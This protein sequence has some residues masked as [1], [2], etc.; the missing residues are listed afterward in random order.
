M[1]TVSTTPTGSRTKSGSK[2]REFRAE[3]LS[4]IASKYVLGYEYKSMKPLYL[5]LLAT[6]GA[7]RP[8]IASI[9]TGSVLAID[10]TYNR[11]SIEI[12]KGYKQ[13]VTPVTHNV[14]RVTF[15]KPGLFEVD[16]S[17][18]IEDDKVVQLCVLIEDSWLK[19]QKY[20]VEKARPILRGLGLWHSK[21]TPEEGHHSLSRGALL[22]YYLERRIPIPFP[23]DPVLGVMIEG[24]L[25]DCIPNYEHYGLD[26]MGVSD[27][28]LLCT[29]TE[30]MISVVT[31]ATKDWVRNCSREPSHELCKSIE[32]IS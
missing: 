23:M 17:G 30:R 9:K 28:L 24:H 15:Y 10:D 5:S 2:G 3:V 27:V 20:D 18:E 11:A 8:I 26:V 14:S 29:S 16:P 13:F 25:Q 12:P 4:Y 19:N 6:T 22:L 21:V 32:P 1:K 7:T 31:D